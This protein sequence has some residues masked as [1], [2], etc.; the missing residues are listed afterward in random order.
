MAMTSP[1]PNKSADYGINLLQ[2]SIFI[3]W[4]Q[5]SRKVDMDQVVFIPEPLDCER[6]RR[7]WPA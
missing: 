5:S 4:D 2:D 7:E 3:L 6:A 1:S